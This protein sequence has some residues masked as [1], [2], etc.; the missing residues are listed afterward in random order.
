[1]KTIAQ[2][3]I[4]YEQLLDAE[5]RACGDLPPFANDADAMRRCR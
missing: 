3:A 4:G 2:F 5:G 1:L